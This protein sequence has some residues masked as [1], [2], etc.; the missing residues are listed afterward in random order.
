MGRHQRRLNTIIPFGSIPF[1]LLLPLIEDSGL[2]TRVAFMMDSAM[3]KIGLQVKPSS[4]S[5]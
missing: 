4:Q 3:H 5:Y 2:L 1:Y